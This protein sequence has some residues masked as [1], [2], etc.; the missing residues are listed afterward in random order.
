MIKK[1]FLLGLILGTIA[2]TQNKPT[3]GTLI[4]SFK[5]VEDSAIL[6]LIDLDKDL[7]IQ[8]I[9]IKNGKFKATF[10]LPGPRFFGL[11]KENPKYEKD[12]LVFWLENSKIEIFGNYD[13]LANASIK[14]SSSNKIYDKYNTIEKSFEH[15]LTRLNLTKSMTND[16]K[17]IDSIV[18]VSKTLKNRYK[19]DLIKFYT[20]NI[21][22]EVSFY[23][24]VGE[25]TKLQS[26]LLKADLKELYKNL[27]EKF[28]ITKEGK[29]LQE[30]IS[31]PEIPKIGDKF[32][33]FEQV[34]PAGKAQLISTNLGKFTI[35]EFWSSFCGNCR[36]EHPRLRKIYYKYHDRGL[37]IIGISGDYK[38]SNWIEAIKT[39]S[40]PW[41]NISDLQGYQNKGFLL[42][43]V[44]A[45]PCLI[46]IDKNG[47][48]LDDNFN[49]KYME[50]ELEKLFNK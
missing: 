4:G 12:M 45:L 13:N 30:Y 25:L 29:L 27:P 23:F 37:N 40:I 5:N 41:L 48:I 21:Q 26:V 11:W 6:N 18:D 2:C 15:D 34:T 7:V 33:D 46:L 42:H 20:D 43:G 17:V 24:L 36:G 22:N 49:T 1:T 31:L 16:Q 35:L 50:G 3:K 38:L 39:D 32:I 19:T 8:K 44:K 14:G 47:I 9:Y 28:I 10:D